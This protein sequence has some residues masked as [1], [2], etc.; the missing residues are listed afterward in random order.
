[1]ILKEPHTKFFKDSFPKNNKHLYLVD[2]DSTII[3]DEGYTHK[4]DDLM[5]LPNVLL[6]LKF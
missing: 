1:M 4:I 2:R 3:A 5:F 6:A